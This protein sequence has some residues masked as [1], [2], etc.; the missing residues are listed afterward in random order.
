MKILELL[1][2]LEEIMETGTGLI[3]TGKIMVDPDEVLEIV[4]EIRAELPEEIEQAKWI[5]TERQRIIEEAKSEYETVLKDAKRQ[6]EMLIESDEIT[7]KATARAEEIIKNAE[8]TAKQLKLSS[9]DYVDGIL[10]NFQEKMDQMNAEY[11]M[12]M[13]NHV[14]KTFN[15]INTTISA[16]REE[17]KDLAY[18]TQMNIKE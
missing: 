11:F 1:D 15:T 10:F 17:I 4:K 8:A 18:N 16:N 13:V 5:K 7:M 12:S 9:F 6:A 3:L 14:E 2:E